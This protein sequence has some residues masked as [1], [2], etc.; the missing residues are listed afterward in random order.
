MVFLL[1]LFIGDLGFKNAKIK[2]GLY[3]QHLLLFS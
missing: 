1:F 3:K 2:K